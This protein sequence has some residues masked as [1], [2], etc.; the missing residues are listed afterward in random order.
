MKRLIAAVSLAVLSVPA[1][2]DAV[3][4]FDADALSRAQPSLSPARSTMGSDYP[5]GGT[6]PY[7]QLDVDRALPDIVAPATRSLVA[8]GGNTRSDVEISASAGGTMTD[9]SPW[10]RQH[11]FIAPP[12]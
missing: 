1:L 5:F 7:N 8:S 4:P 9:E 11:D 3:N 2:A 10:A 12:Q 6:P